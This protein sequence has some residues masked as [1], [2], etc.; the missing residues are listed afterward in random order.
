MTTP[1]I[2]CL[3]SAIWDTI[4]QVD[5]IPAAGVKVL[6][7]QAVQAASGMAASAAV[8]IARLGGS[9]QFWSRLGDDDAGHRYI[10]QFRQEG[11]NTDG[12]RPIAGTQTPF[13][14]II[15]DSQGE[16]VVL[17]FYDPTVPVDPS[18]LPLERVADASAVL[19]DVRWTQGAAALLNQARQCGIP[20][21]LDADT[22]PEAVLRELVPLASHVLFSEPALHIY[23]PGVDPQQ[24]LRDVANTHDVDM[25]GVTLGALGAAV[26]TRESG[27]ISHITAPVI[28]AVDTL[29]AGDIWHGTFA[30][31]L[32]QHWP[33][34]KIVHWA[35]VAAAMKCEVFGGRLG[36]PTLAAL[37]ARINETPWGPN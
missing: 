35:N 4:F 32:S 2:I 28:Q 29:N 1:S 15:V 23:C 11:V 24:A 19:V 12:L 5:D 18:W 21:I 36:A 8:T 34:Q 10:E 6:P 20:A 9:V 33:V 37:Q 31:G 17:P 27:A 26:W 7:R 16:R 22:A 13:S 25:V 3:G 30:W 14:S